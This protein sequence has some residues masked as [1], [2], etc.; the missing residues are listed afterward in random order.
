MQK[1]KII[2]KKEMGAK[3]VQY[4]PSPKTPILKPMN[5]A[6]DIVFTD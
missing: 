1:I 5:S 6:L 4:L 3:F 2:K